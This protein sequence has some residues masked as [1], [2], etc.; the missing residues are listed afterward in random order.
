MWRIAHYL[1]TE[2]RFRIVDLF[3]TG[4]QIYEKLPSGL[5]GLDGEEEL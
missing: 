2:R 1:V 3:D 4:E 5:W